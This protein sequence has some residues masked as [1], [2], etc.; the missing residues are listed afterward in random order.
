MRG[1]SADSESEKTMQAYIPIYAFINHG[2]VDRRDQS[3][4]G[5]VCHHGTQPA[6]IFLTFPWDGRARALLAVS[7]RVVYLTVWLEVVALLVFPGSFIQASSG[8]CKKPTPV[9]FLIPEDQ[10]SMAE[11]CMDALDCLFLTHPQPPQKRTKRDDVAG[12]ESGAAMRQ[13]FEDAGQGQVFQF[14][15]ALSPDQ[16]EQL[17]TQARVSA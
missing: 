1:V 3:L 7:T 9:T 4:A 16:R 11:V 14:F 2:K 13:R 5:H 6:A 8:V 15:D 10:T 17:L 12:D